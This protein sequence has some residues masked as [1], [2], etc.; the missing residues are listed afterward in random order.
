LVR[1][2]IDWMK[3]L[4]AEQRGALAGSRQELDD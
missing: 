4:F 2:V 3:A 1:A